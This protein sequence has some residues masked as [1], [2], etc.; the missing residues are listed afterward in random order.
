MRLRQGFIALMGMCLVGLIAPLYAQPDDA[1]F[2]E[3]GESVTS[4]LDDE[5]WFE[6]WFF[7][8]T[9]GDAVTIRLEAFD[10][11]DPYLVLLNPDGDVITENDD[12]ETGVIRDSLLQSVTLPR[13]GIYG[14]IATRFQFENGTT[15]GDYRLTLSLAHADEEA[16]PQPEAGSDVAGQLRY[17]TPVTDSLSDDNF[18]DVWRFV[19]SAGDTISITMQRAADDANLDPLL[20]LLDAEGR[21]LLSNDDAALGTLDAA[22]EDFTLPADGTYTVIAT[23]FGEATGA[24]AGEYT[25]EI[26]TDAAQVQGDTPAPPPPSDG[27]EITYGEFI[28]GTLAADSSTNVVFQ[29]TAGDVVTISIKRAP[30]S[31]LNPSVSLTALDDSLEFGAFNEAFNSAADARIVDA[32]LPADGLYQVTALADAGT[33]GDFVLHLFSEAQQ[34]EVTIAPEESAEPEPSEESAEPEPSEESAEPEPSEEPAEPE[35]DPAQ[36]NIAPEAASLAFVLAWPGAPDFDLAVIDPAGDALDFRSPESPSGG[37]FSGDANGGCAFSGDAPHEAALWEADYPA[38]TY[39]IEIA[40][41]F[42]C[43]AEDPVPYTL[44]IWQGGEIIETLEG[45]LAQ[46]GFISYE[47][48]VD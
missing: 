9:A 39:Q 27:D 23:R 34:D 44:T 28:S 43:G 35:D 25:L 32:T 10:S 36:P 24:T 5:T 33:G 29:G 11:L 1:P 7:E 18:E 15:S 20:R 3:Y 47:R 31:T 8:G 16:A 30:G 42:P 21:E 2:I 22:I 12:I 6:E 17:N 37:V 45:E 4:T 19:G 14:I 40:H 26:L 41:V 48:S 13:D 38:G 46:G